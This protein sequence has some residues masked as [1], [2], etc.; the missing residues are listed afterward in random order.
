M[1]TILIADDSMFMRRILKDIVPDQ[2]R[3][4]EAG[5]ASQALEQF[6]KE[7]PDLVLL[8]IIMPDE[9]EAGVEVLKKLMKAN[10]EA[11][12]VMITAVGQQAMVDQCKKIGATDYITKPFD[13]QQVS[14]TVEKCL[15]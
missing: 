6:N 12:V 9:Q 3:V 11:K 4:I 15:V 7:H 1:K 8:D 14:Q 13:E 2:Y 5:S 10:P